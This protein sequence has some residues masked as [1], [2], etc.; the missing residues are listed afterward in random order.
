VQS[1]FHHHRHAHFGKGRPASAAFGLAH[2]LFDLRRVGHRKLTAIQ[3]A[4]SQPVIKRL[5]MLRGPGLGFEGCGHDLLEERRRQQRPALRERPIG[6]ALTAQSFHMRGQ[7]AR[8]GERMKDQAS[9]QFQGADARR[10]A[11]THARLAH[12]THQGAGRKR[13]IEQSLERVERDDS[14]GSHPQGNAQ[15]SIFVQGKS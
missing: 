10:T 4:Q 1:Q 8:G 3:S 15:L 11:P 14:I 12:Q 2:L 6:N 7:C 5:G 9:D 13:L